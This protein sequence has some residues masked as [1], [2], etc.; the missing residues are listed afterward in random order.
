MVRNRTR[1]EGSLVA[2]E[3]ERLRAEKIRDGLNDFRP[4]A[5]EDKTKHRQ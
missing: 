1:L 4:I 2:T 3:G 5:E